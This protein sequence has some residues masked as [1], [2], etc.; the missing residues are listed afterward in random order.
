MTKSEVKSLLALIAEIWRSAP[1]A[2]AASLAIWAELLEDM[3][4]AVAKKA[5]KM[6]ALTGKPFAPTISEIRGAA[7]EI[8]RP[9]FPTPAEA[10][11]QAKEFIN[12]ELQ[13]NRLHP[14]VQRTLECFGVG[15]YA[16]AESNHARPQFMRMYEQIVKRAEEEAMLPVAFREE[17][18]ALRGGQAA[19]TENAQKAR[20][21]IEGLAKGKGMK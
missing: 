19:L 18:E 6:L 12:E 7:I 10:Y 13:W 16:N 20:E 9:R 4:L 5:V 14:L 2:T 8:T 11:G 17:I 3:P 15:N 1:E 21:M